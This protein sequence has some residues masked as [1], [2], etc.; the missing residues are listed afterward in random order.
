MA[1]ASNPRAKYIKNLAIPFAEEVGLMAHVR[2]VHRH[3]GMGCLMD[4]AVYTSQTGTLNDL[5][6]DIVLEL[7]QMAGTE[8]V[9]RDTALVDYT[10]GFVTPMEA[11]VPKGSVVSSEWRMMKNQYKDDSGILMPGQQSI[12]APSDTGYWVVDNL[13]GRVVV[14]NGSNWS[15]NM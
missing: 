14:W 11:F 12:L 13:T 1:N 15:D 7:T 9:D 5:G 3:D 2:C 6:T 8:T 10:Q 4:I